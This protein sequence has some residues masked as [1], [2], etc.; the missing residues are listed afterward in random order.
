MA[1]TNKNKAD[2]KAKRKDKKKG[3]EFKKNPV[4]EEV[5]QE[6]KG[7]LK[8][9]DKSKSIVKA[10]TKDQDSIHKTSKDSINKSKEE[11][12][13]EEVDQQE[14][15]I[16]ILLSD[17]P[18]SLEERIQNLKEKIQEQEKK[19]VHLDRVREEDHSGLM[20]IAN[21]CYFNSLIQTLYSNIQFRKIIIE[22][23]IP[24]DHYNY[25]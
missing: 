14:T 3:D 4:P 8:S 15:E 24:E 19:I 25:W 9:D 16:S 2:K 5:I 18:K 23:K 10:N 22:I 6:N 7:Y 1:R 21:T 13:K 12:S 20:N 17:V 11:K